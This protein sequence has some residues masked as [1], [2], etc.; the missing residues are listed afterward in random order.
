MF[1][2]QQQLLYPL[3]GLPFIPTVPCNFSDNDSFSVVSSGIPGPPGPAGP[4]GP[5]G[6]VSPVTVTSVTET[7]Y[8]VLATDY[9]LCVSVNSPSSVVL[10]V[11]ALGAVFIVKDCNGNASTN[12]ITITALTNIDGAANATINSDYGS[13]TLIFNGTEWNIV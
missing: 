6:A 4:P 13:I 12:P 10:P 11:S 1:Q 9:F 8:Q 3:Y 2:Q 7:P 5:T